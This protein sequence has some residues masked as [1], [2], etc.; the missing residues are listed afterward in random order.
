MI[1]IYCIEEVGWDVGWFHGE[2]KICTWWITEEW[3]N[4]CRKHLDDESNND[5]EISEY[6]WFYV[7]K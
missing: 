7:T 3:R 2:I 6:K 5:D 1:G 4:G